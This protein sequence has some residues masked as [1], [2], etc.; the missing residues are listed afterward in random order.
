MF[1]SLIEST[2]GRSLVA[3]HFATDEVSALD[4]IPF[5]AKENKKTQHKISMTPTHFYNFA[6]NFI[7]YPNCRYMTL[8]LNFLNDLPILQHILSIEYCFDNI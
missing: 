2:D 6:A 8:N 3:F 1:I 7:I 4:L 5:V